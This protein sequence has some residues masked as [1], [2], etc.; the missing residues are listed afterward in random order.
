MAPEALLQTT[1]PRATSEQS[2]PGPLL[3]LQQQP[4]AHS[5]RPSHT[6]ELPRRATRGSARQRPRAPSTQKTPEA[7]LQALDAL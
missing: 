5:A 1:D 4:Q 6:L 2:P 3:V 7:L